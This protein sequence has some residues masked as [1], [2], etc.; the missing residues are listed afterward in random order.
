MNPQWDGKDCINCRK[1]LL[2]EQ[3]DARVVNPTL[4]NTQFIS[5]PLK[6]IRRLRAFGVGCTLVDCGLTTR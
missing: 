2:A 5:L 3:K 1:K 4:N 6:M